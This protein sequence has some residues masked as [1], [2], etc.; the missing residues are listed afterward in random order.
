MEKLVKV[1]EF[2]KDDPSHYD[3]AEYLGEM[4]GYSVYMPVFNDRDAHIGFPR[5]IF[6]NDDEIRWAENEEIEEVI[7]TFIDTEDEDED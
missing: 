1:C 2:M 4:N 3:Y 7:I 5:Y 6:M